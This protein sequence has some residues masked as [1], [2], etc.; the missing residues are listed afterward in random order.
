MIPC[1][2]LLQDLG[3]ALR[4]DLNSQLS[5]SSG[6]DAAALGSL[7]ARLE[8]GAH[9]AGWGASVHKSEL[10]MSGCAFCQAA[11]HPVSASVALAVHCQQRFGCNA[12]VSAPLLS[13]HSEESL[14]GLPVR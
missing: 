7:E 12:V 4:R 13:P 11:K 2:P 8:V 5:A 10:N 1:W 14:S 9:S 6:R 3:T